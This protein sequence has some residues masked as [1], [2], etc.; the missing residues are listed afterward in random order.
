MDVG[1]LI[2][3]NDPLVTASLGDSVE[4][5]EGDPA[6]FDVT[7]NR[8]SG[9]DVELRLTTA[10][11]SATSGQDYRATTRTLTIP[12]GETAA[13]FTV[14]TFDD[15]VVEST[16]DATVR[17]EVVDSDTAELGTSTATLTI[18]DD[19]VVPTDP[20]AVVVSLSGAAVEEGDPFA[21]PLPVP[22]GG[23]TLDFVVRLSEP[24]DGDVTLDF[25][26]RAATATAGEDFT[27]TSGQVTIAD[28]QSEATIQVPVLAD[29]IDEFDEDLTLALTAVSGDAVLPGGELERTGRILDD[30]A[31]SQ[32]RVNDATV[33]EGSAAELDVTL[34]G[35]SGKD[36]TVEYAFV[37]GTA[38]AGADYVAASGTLEFPAGTTSRTVSVATLADTDTGE[39]IEQFELVLSAPTNAALDDPRGTVSIVDLDLDGLPTVTAV[40]LE[41]TTTVEADGDRTAL[42]PVRLSAESDEDVAVTWSTQQLTATDGEDYRADGGQVVI[43]AGATSAQIPVTIIGD[44]EVESDEDFLVLLTAAEGAVITGPTGRVTIEDDDTED[45]GTDPGGDGD[46]DGAPDPDG[47]GDE[48]GAAGDEDLAATGGGGALLGL[49]GLALGGLLRRRRDED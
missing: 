12:A 25:E 26:T 3:D 6:T 23:A 33:L 47:D 8:D 19:D 44:D 18:T 40:F 22:T 27:A 2:D 32:L 35:E 28:G 17:L 14:P 21:L 37:D 45:D 42:V 29:T 10:D 38:T 36:I 41:D 48:D 46:G 11:G 39:L 30:D 34:D 24:A 16:E 20:D 1:G 5:A 49:L 43:P 7:L 13:T 15:S 4:V 31:A 9:K